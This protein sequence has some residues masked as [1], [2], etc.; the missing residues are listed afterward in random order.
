MTKQDYVLLAR[1]FRQLR[2]FPYEKN[3]ARYMQWLVI[4]QAIAATLQAENKRFNLP[5]FLK[6]CGVPEYEK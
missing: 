4:V 1:T 6:A 5:T 2:P 3:K